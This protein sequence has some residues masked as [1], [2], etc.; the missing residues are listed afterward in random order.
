MS[1]DKDNLEELI[2]RFDEL[3]DKEHMKL[4]DMFVNIDIEKAKDEIETVC[5]NCLIGKFLRS[6]DSKHH[7]GIAIGLSIACGFDDE[8]LDTE[9]SS[10]FHWLKH[11]VAIQEKQKTIDN[12]KLN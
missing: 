5:K 3:S 8:E 1:V 11:I 6:I 7:E 9:E 12:A 10:A 4:M 2:D